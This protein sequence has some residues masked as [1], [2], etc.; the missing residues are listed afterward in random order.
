MA[1]KLTASMPPNLDLGPNYVV[2][3]GARDPVTG[4]PVSGVVVQDFS[5]L[6]TNVGGGDLSNPGFSILLGVQV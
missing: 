1:E 5:I 2:T 4:D 3:L 6:C